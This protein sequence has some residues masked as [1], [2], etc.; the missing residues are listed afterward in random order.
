MPANTNYPF[1][2]LVGQDE[3]KDAL[4]LAAV[5]PRVQGVLL[6]GP[7]GTGK[8][9]AVRGLA[10][11]LPVI[12]HSLCPN[13]C[14]PA[15][16]RTAPDRLCPECRRK[17][18]EGEPIAYTAPQAV[19]E[20]PLNATLDDV[21]GGANARLSLEQQ[22]LRFDPGILAHAHQNIL[23]IDE[24]NL[25]ARDVLDAIL[26]AAATGYCVVRRGRLAA[27]Y[28]AR[29][30][31]IGS[32]NP[33]EGFLRPQIIDRIGLRVYVHGVTDAAERLA[34]TRRVH[35]FQDDPERF[36]ADYA[37]PT[38]AA[39]ASIS[40]ARA[41]LPG[42]RLSAAAEEIGIRLITRLGIESQR[43]EI[44]LFAAAR[45][46]A[47]IDER[48]EVTAADVL[49]V[50]PLVVRRRRSSGAEEFLAASRAEEVV[51]QAAIA[52]LRRRPRQP[53]TLARPAP[54]PGGGDGAA[55]NAPA[56]GAPAAP[57]AAARATPAR[58]SRRPAP[59]GPAT[60]R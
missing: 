59:V 30:V 56:V 9:T 20:L 41:A 60:P 40:T 54:A 37:P 4:I 55:P 31:L 2:A 8:T 10:D 27:S 28:P 42:V 44:V 33:E 21:V 13:G 19:V 35:A 38:L 34:V 17:L 52:A 15:W 46:Y 43:T 32:M 58:R 18:A 57:P 53:R 12:T 26:D 51:I 1:T 25:V 29:F 36:A 7:K 23:Y 16:A 11:L 48:P 14:D 39:A 5:N 49:T 50:A 22:H 6:I 45:A 24:I 47:A 3:V